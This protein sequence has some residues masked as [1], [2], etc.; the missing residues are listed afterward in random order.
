M[1]QHTA[2][3]MRTDIDLGRGT[4]RMLAFSDAT[5]A[6]RSAVPWE[7]TYVRTYSKQ[8]KLTS[9]FSS[10][11]LALNGVCF[12]TNA[13]PEIRSFLK[14]LHL[15]RVSSRVV[16]SEPVLM[17]WAVSTVITSSIPSTR[18]CVEEE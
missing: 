6:G 5:A 1:T 4:L 13:T 17:L 8:K 9:M 16:Y 12:S 3:E 11:P 7:A 18:G 2:G 10:S 15:S 14:E